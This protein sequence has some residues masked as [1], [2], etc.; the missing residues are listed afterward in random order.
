VEVPLLNLKQAYQELKPEFDQLWQEINQD[1][2]YVLGSRLSQFE[3][4]FAQYLGVKHIVGVADGLDAL[5]LSL[6]ALDIKHGDEVIVPSFTF[7]ATWLAVSETGA[8]PIG[9]DVNQDYLIDPNNIKKAITPK[10]KAIMPVHL[11]GKVCDMENIIAIAKEFNLKI[12]ED[13]AQAHGAFI[14]NKKAGSFGDC[15]GFS[16]YPGKNLGCFGDGGCIATND[17]ALAEKLLALRNYGSTVS[18]EHHIKAGNSRL[19]DL[20]AGILSIKLKHLDTWNNRRRK[21][22]KI[23]LQELSGIHDLILPSDEVGHVWHIFAIR[24]SRRNALQQFL[25]S[26]NI[27]TKI[28][29]PKPIHLQKAYSDM[30]MK[31]GDF[32][33]TESMCKEVLSL[34]MGPHLT[35]TEALFCAKQVKDF[36]EA[37]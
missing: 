34:P 1:S 15:A 26:K 12:I 17:D 24:T 22:A 21:I 27:G 33:V 3:K 14:K 30:N 18:Y 36:Y 11:Y 37:I 31:A 25:S 28:H 8:T 7:I 10:T 6:K 23:Y 35:E 2:S 32:S 4:A 5:T 20:H 16:F 13:S 29:Y 9:V 19:D